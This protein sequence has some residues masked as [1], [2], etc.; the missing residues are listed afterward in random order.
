MNHL[1]R[2]KI[3]HCDL[4]TK[5]IL[6]KKKK[7]FYEIRLCDFGMSQYKKKLQKK[8]RTIIGNKRYVAPE[9]LRGGRFSEASDVYSFGVILWEI[10]CEKIPREE[11]SDQ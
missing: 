8:N 11:M 5:N 3:L 10:L 9:V 4:K 7:D 1:H 6:V 2:N